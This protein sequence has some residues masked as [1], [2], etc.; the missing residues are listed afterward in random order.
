M[1]RIDIAYD[2]HAYTLSNTSLEDLKA[3]VLATAT[4]GEPF[5]LTVNEGAGTLK[6]VEVL[7][8]ASSQLSLAE[9]RREPDDYADSAA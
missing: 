2:G 9:I 8:T 6:A 5:W 4:G 3:R 1:N 7:I